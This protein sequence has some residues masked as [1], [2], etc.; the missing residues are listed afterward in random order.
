MARTDPDSVFAVFRVFLRLGCTAFGGPVAHLGYF[1][2][3]L[4]ARRRWLDEADYADLVA[5]CQCLPGPTSSQVGIGL[6]LRRAGM[7]GAAA[8]WLGFTLPSALLLVLLALGLQTVAGGPALDGVLHGLKLAAVAV[9]AQAV[10]GMGRS[11]CP[12]RPRA[13]L[14]VAAMLVV[15]VGPPTAGP[16]LAIGLGAVVGRW[17]LPAVEAP[18]AIGGYGVSRRTGAVLL[19][20]FVLLLVGLPLVAA[21]TGAA[22]WSAVAAFYRAGALVFG[23]GHVVLPLLQAAAVPPG[24]IDHGLFLAGYGAAQAVPGPLFAFAAYLGAAMQVPPGGVAGAAVLLVALF[25]PGVLLVLGALPFWETLRR[26]AAVQRAL[27]GVNAVV[28]G[29]LAAALYDP[30]IVQAIEGRMDVAL[31]VAAG[32]LLMVGRVSPVVVV[33]LAAVAGALTV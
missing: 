22:G 33:G 6:G 24:W 29:V 13:G 7:A 5:L 28:V 31:A 20:A 2:A 14:A 23:G 12:D 21:A 1:R 3:E 8:A 27:A 30:V 18:P 15:L 19:L 9:V 11:L 26:H 17:A 16:L 32:G 10:W 25:A 4:V